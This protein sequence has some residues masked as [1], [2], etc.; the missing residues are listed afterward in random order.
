[1]NRIEYLE[2]KSFNLKNIRNRN[3]EQVHSIGYKY[4]LLEIIWISQRMKTF[5]IFEMI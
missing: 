4:I 2:I 5:F 1:M 3:G